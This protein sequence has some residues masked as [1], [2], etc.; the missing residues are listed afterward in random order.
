MALE[1]Q[2]VAP[3][4]TDVVNNIVPD[5]SQIPSYQLAADSH[6]V[7]SGNGS[8][9]ASLGQTI[10]NIG[11]SINNAP[12]F[13]GLA[14]GSGIT[15]MINSAIAVGNLFNNEQDQTAYVNYGKW[16][17]DYDS[18]L[19]KYYR[20]NATSID[21]AGFV[22]TS[23]VP[24]TLGIKAF[25]LGQ[26]VLTTAARTGVF[27]EN[28]AAATGLLAD[29]GASYVT[30]AATQIAASNQVISFYSAN[31]LKAIA[32]R[33]GQQALEAAAFEGAVVATSF[34]SPFF[35]NMD[36]WDMVKNAGVGILLGGAI[37][38]VLSTIG[39]RS[40]IKREVLSFDEVGRT[41]IYQHAVDNSVP[42]NIKLVNMF[43][44]RDT[45]E[46][47]IK[48][49]D[50]AV[51]TIDKDIVRNNI[52]NANS[53]ITDVN[54]KLRT[55]IR[56]MTA[57]TNDDVGNYFADNIIRLTS[58]DG[59]NA[60]LG[61]ESF[62]RVADRASDNVRLINR[63]QQQL[64]LDTANTANNLLKEN[65]RISWSKL[66]GAN[67]GN[68]TDDIPD[69]VS[70]ADSVKLRKGQT[71]ED[72]VNKAGKQFKN[73]KDVPV[74]S[75]LTKDVA[76]VQSRYLW[77]SKV[78][79]N[80]SRVIQ[81]SQND[82][83]LMEAIS[84]QGTKFENVQVLNREGTII[85]TITPT[86]L[87]SVIQD[88]KLRLVQELKQQ[89][90]SIDEIAERTNVNPGFIDQTAVSDNAFDN[91]YYKQSIAKDLNI[92]HR[93]V[94]YR[95]Q[96]MG[97]KQRADIDGLRNQ[98]QIS[99]KL[100]LES[101]NAA[102][103]A[104]KDNA[105]ADAGSIYS[106]ATF[107]AP[108]GQAT[109]GNLT[110]ILPDAAKVYDL[111]VEKANRAGA[112]SRLFSF[113]NGSYHDAESVMQYIGNIKSR[114]DI[115][116]M[117]AVEN[118]LET[119]LNQIRNNS[120]AATEWS[121]T[122]EL[123]ARSGEQYVM[124]DGKLVARKIAQWK[125]ASLDAGAA[126]PNPIQ[127]PIL[128]PGAKEEIT[129]QYPEARQVWEAHIELNG[130][131]V[132]G[133]KSLRASQG[134]ESTWDAETAYAIKPNPK[135]LPYHAF[136]V[137]DSITG[138]GHMTMIHAR[139]AKTLDQMMVKIKSELPEYKL[140]TKADS[141]A[142]HEALGDFD[143][144]KAL[145]ENYIDSSLASRGINSQYLPRTNG[146]DIADEIMNWHKQQVRS[147]NA[148]I[149]S[150]KYERTFRALDDMGKDFNSLNNSRYSDFDSLQTEVSRNPYTEYKKLALNISNLSE[151]PLLTN[152]NQ[153]LDRAVSS[154]WNKAQSLFAKAKSPE[155]L[156]AI[157]DVFKNQG[158]KTA[159]YD[160]ATDLL[161]NHPADS[162]VLSKFIRGANSLLATTF[163]RLDVLNAINNKL[164]S[165]ILTSTEMQHVLRGIKSADEAT[166]GKLA[167]IAQVK[168]PGQE[169]SILSAPKLIMKANQNFVKEFFGKAGD[170]SG[171]LMARYKANGWVQDNLSD[172]QKLMDNLTLNGT[173]STAM[174][175]GKLKSAFEAA[176]KVG[177]MG[178]KWTGNKMIEQMNRFMAADIMRQITD[179]AVNAGIIEAKEANIYINTFVNRTQ[180]NLNA[181]QRPLAFQGPIGMAMG[182]FQSYQ[183]NL[184]QQM[185]RYVAPGARKDAAMLL[186]MQGGMYG[187][188]GLPGF[189]QFNEHIIAQA[190]GNHEHNDVYSTIYGK[191]NYDLANFF[192]YG[193]PSNLLRT[194]LYSRGD[195]TPQH[196]TILPGSIS[197][198]PF[199]G[200]LSQFL[201]N[202][203]TTAGDIAN[204]NGVWPS[205][206]TG[207]EHNAI[208]RP[209]AGLAQALRATTGN[210]QVYS[211][212]ASGD[213]LSANDLFSLTTLTRLAGGRP[214]DESIARDN[215][216][217]MQAY[218]K[219]DSLQ[220]SQM[221]DTLTRA[222]SGGTGNPD[223]E[224]FYNDYLANGGKSAGFNRWMMKAYTNS[225]TSQA[226]QLRSNLS[227]PFS[228]RMQAIMGGGTADSVATLY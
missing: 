11:D 226:E 109:T 228:Q 127:K 95:P 21:T 116:G 91:F 180:V 69:V 34:K 62:M 152:I 224:K 147:Y 37:G 81:V 45:F 22:A 148:D 122:R 155:E 129:F 17:Q 145:N 108:N 85:D 6:N 60:T 27:G 189:Q 49:T 166:V 213:L 56:G 35:D 169:D 84:R 188:N 214:L 19:G 114:L 167:Q 10:D 202:L 78:E 168:I 36:S 204:G 159:Y 74:D 201:G 72:A 68:V 183:F 187:L 186:G 209:L 15:G 50:G 13:W 120:A 133:I 67:K 32:V 216:F 162:A 64:G 42:D 134:L 144:K 41:A 175:Q 100:N 33:T 1:T 107:Y 154:V 182:L 118:R 117:G 31:A 163:L 165:V 9:F 221:Q 102:A 208:N 115:E 112:G 23:L 47:F 101:W 197:E 18:D 192:L 196:P 98:F 160:A 20:D 73:N 46:Q 111:L 173:E 125:E 124:R 190:A 48:S 151:Y 61:A 170:G 194:N 59:I 104:V 7:A 24:G 174:V 79:L 198:I 55:Q 39:V 66:Y 185:F 30:K 63:V 57:G 132:N 176:Q 227:S 156:D 4:E 179:V 75:A 219:A 207:L 161:A 93:Q 225:T 38:G 131:R 82:I 94:F 130:Q 220:R 139:D 205:I 77:A 137:D 52:G 96:Y 106:Q 54:N 142:Y 157:N 184:M 80:P 92:D 193:M 140:I 86:N 191:D 215:M 164:G 43:E 103:Q 172:A 14:I 143:Y 153:T 58:K 28:I 2:G 12:K 199:V 89:G 83:P 218:Q 87:D 223:T 136:V 150:T 5:Y 217:R 210:G 200:K 135:T 203:K 178:E 65:E 29:A 53:S 3:T 44:N 212:T 123:V 71:L 149:I 99:G 206:L 211:T 16:V 25:N 146:N 113:S 128:N 121:V 138:A 105:V 141:R 40:A 97:I 51:S 70:L 88:S 126:S 171:N 110:Q 8:W 158:F 181:A 90:K 76:A 195:I 26:K 119:V 177:N 222:F